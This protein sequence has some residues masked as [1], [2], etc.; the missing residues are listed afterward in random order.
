[1]A[2]KMLMV[3]YALMIVVPICQIT[4]Y[5]CENAK[6]Q[7]WVD[8]QNSGVGPGPRPEFTDK[9]DFEQ[10]ETFRYSM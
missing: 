4:W 5:R 3:C 9:T 10:W 7:R 2:F 8:E 1:M 6:R